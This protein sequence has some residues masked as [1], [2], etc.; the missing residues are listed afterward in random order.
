M[1]ATRPGPAGSGDPL[2]GHTDA[3]YAVAFAPDG[4]TLATASAD[5]TVLLWDVTDPTQPRRLGTPHRPHRRRV[6]RWRSPRTGTPWPP[7]APTTPCCCGTSPTRPDRAGSATRSPATPTRCTRWRSPRTGTPWPPPAAD[8]TVLLWDVTDPAQPRRL[9]DPLTGHT[10]AVSAVAFAP[11]GHTLATGSCDNTVLLWDVTDP[12]RPRRWATPHRPHRR[13]V[14]GGVRPGRAHP[15]HRQ[16]R[17]DRAAVGRHRPGPAAPTGRPADRPHRRGVRGGV[18]PGRAHPGHR[19][20]RRDGAAVGRHA[21]RPARAGSGDPSPATP[22]R[23]TRWRSPRTGTPWPPPAPT[24][25]CCCG[26]SATRPAPAGS[27]NPLT[28]HTDA[29][30]AVAFAPDGHTLATASCRQDGAAV[31]RH[32]PGPAPPRSA[33]R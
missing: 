22:T 3:V 31:G 27:G 10:D 11:D 15:G 30:S 24:R 33:T 18:R 16:L 20:R 25:P 21:T 7:P 14:R 6:P 4:H 28:G 2:T 23:C 17:Q 26:T 9:G 29:V 5:S 13:G 8:K 1:S 12:A 32:R 19:Q